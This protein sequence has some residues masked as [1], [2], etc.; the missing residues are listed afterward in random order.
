VCR[1]LGQPVALDFQRTP[2]GDAAAYLEKT[3]KVPVRLDQKALDEQ[4]VRTDLPVT[5]KVAGVSA[6]AALNLL[7]RPLELTWTFRDSGL[8]I[9]TEEAEAADLV[10]RSY[11]VSDLVSSH[12]EIGQPTSADDLIYMFERA[13]DP[14]RYWQRA[15][16]GASI[17]STQ[18][19]QAVTL[20]MRDTW[21]T[22]RR[23]PAF[24]DELR[25]LNEA[26]RA[27][28]EVVPAQVAPPAWEQKIRQALAQRISIN[29]VDTALDQAIEA[30][31]EKLKIEIQV[32]WP[33]LEQV[34]FARDTKF[35]RVISELDAQD[36]L[37]MLLRDVE[38]AWT[39]RDE[40]LFITT[41]E[42]ANNVVIPRLYDVRD[43]AGRREPSGEMSYDF[44]ELTALIMCSVEPTT[45]GAGTGPSSVW[46]PPFQ[47][48]A[49]AVLLV[50]Q[51]W[52]VHREVEELLADLRRVREAAMAQKGKDIVPVPAR[53]DRERRLLDALA[54][55]ITL[56][57][58]EIPL[59]D[60]VSWLKDELKVQMQ[61]DWN[62]LQELGLDADSRVTFCVS[63]MRG[64]SA[65]AGVLRPLGLT[66]TFWHGVVWITTPEAAGVQFTTRVYDVRDLLPRRWSRELVLPPP[67]PE[68][69]FAGSIVEPPDPVTE[70]ITRRVAPSS[71]NTAGG[72]GGIMLYDLGPLRVLVVNQTE[73]VHTQI[74][75]LLAELRAARP[76]A[77][78][79][80]GPPT[81]R[82]CGRFWRGRSACVGRSNHSPTWCLPL[83][84]R[85]NSISAWTRRPCTRPRLTRKCR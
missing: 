16:E 9:T 12:Q 71:W 72:A 8:I 1:A 43:L 53:P 52:H 76:T 23:L 46:I 29:F 51:T 60:A 27:K 35:T 32:D 38:L 84:A 2:L 55:P 79:R 77:A 4:G 7:A 3:L 17:V 58:I 59:S 33:A 13:V 48:D 80:P 83:T 65:L 66:W 74:E 69:G 21:R 70:A 15:P 75:A 44:E 62:C 85:S 20:T 78:G 67:N 63:G 10:T 61:V 22:H 50:P 14:D 42:E 6:E 11:D 41:A 24:L 30:L 34:G 68:G 64:V 47:T 40:V 82:R 5:L 45:W 73:D 31:K 25:R 36:A 54:R 26:A 39:V 18:S 49:L 28:P 19:G 56:D 37:D 81:A 57:F